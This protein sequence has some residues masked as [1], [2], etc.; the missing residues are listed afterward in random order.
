MR[1]L[2]GDRSAGRAL[3]GLVEKFDL[4]Q[5][6]ICSDQIGQWTGDSK[7][8]VKVENSN[9]DRHFLRQQPSNVGMVAQCG[10]IHRHLIVRAAIETNADREKGLKRREEKAP[11]TNIR[12]AGYC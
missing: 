1:M 12:A 11:S 9:L 8:T 3:A 6:A 10:T 4:W 7:P 2:D 5:L